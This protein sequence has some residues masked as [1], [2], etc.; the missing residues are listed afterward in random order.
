[1]RAQYAFHLLY[2]VLYFI[3]AFLQKNIQKFPRTPLQIADIH[4]ST[5]EEM[6]PALVKTVKESVPLCHFVR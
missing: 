6:E 5:A 4:A 1:M 3:P 2:D